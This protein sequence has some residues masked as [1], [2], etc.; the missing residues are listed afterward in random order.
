M[1]SL[2][3]TRERLLAAASELFAER[4]FHGTKARDIAQRAHVNL[5]SGNYHYG[6]K[7]ALYLEVL[8][9]QFREIRALFARR[10]ASLPPA[11]LRR[12]SNRELEELLETRIRTMLEILLGPPPGLHGTLMQREMTDPS[13]ALPV[14]V[15]EFIR[16]MKGEMEQIVARRM[17]ELGAREVERCVMSIVGQVLVFRFV[18]PGILRLLGLREY[19]RVF[20]RQMASHIA[21]FSLDGMSGVA[22]RTRRRRHGR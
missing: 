19:P 5:A 2:P 9:T 10:H 13:E 7:K 21:T 14:I 22:T 8:R 18:R 1:H 4:G 12:L 15:E 3:A 11:E 6:S 20:A 17:P 16:P